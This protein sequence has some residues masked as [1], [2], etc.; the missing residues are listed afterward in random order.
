MENHIYFDPGTTHAPLSPNPQEH[1]KELGIIC[2]IPDL[3]VKASSSDIKRFGLEKVKEFCV[4][5]YVFGKMIHSIK[6]LEPDKLF[7]QKHFQDDNDI[8]FGL[9]L[10]LDQFLK[11]SKCF[12]H[13][14]KS[15][16]LVLQ[17][18]GLCFRKPCDS[19]CLF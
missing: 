4:S 14:E 18:P 12:D 8:P 5:N 15:F 1:C 9:V 10:S 7:D 19:L 6:K 13:L 16:E 2:S 17:Q 11:H 3:F